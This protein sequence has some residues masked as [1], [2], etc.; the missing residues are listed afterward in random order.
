MW[1]CHT[2][3]VHIDSVMEVILPMKLERYQLTKEEYYNLRRAGITNRE[4][5]RRYL[6]GIKIK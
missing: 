3:K 5:E 4:M 2:K 1:C 6:A